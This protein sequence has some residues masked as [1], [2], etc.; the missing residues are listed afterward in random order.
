[1]FSLG[2]YVVRL[3][4]KKDILFRITYISPNQIAR[5]KGVSYRVV[6]DAPLADLELAE[7]MRYTS[8]EDH[9]MSAIESS[10]QSII[11]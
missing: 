10:V 5:L 4:Y 8:K 3:S 6:A 11:K 7:S 1:M 2:D 9:I